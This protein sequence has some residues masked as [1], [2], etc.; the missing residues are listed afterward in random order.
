MPGRRLALL[1]MTVI[2]LLL[3]AG[4]PASAAVGDSVSDP[5]VISGPLPITIATDTTTATSDATDPQVQCGPLRPNATTF[6]SY[7]PSVPTYLTF[8]GDDRGRAAVYAVDG[9]GNLQDLGGC[10][11]GGV[12]ETLSAGQQYVIM[13]FSCCDPGDP[14]G[15]GTL[16]LRAVPPPL[17]AD[18]N[19]SRTVL[20]RPAGDLARISGTFS[21]NTPADFGGNGSLYQRHGSRADVL[22]GWFFLNMTCDESGGGIWSV[23]VPIPGGALSSGTARLTIDWG[24]V[25]WNERTQDGGLIDMTV[26]L[27][28]MRG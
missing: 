27:A 25:S 4:S 24:A 9:G 13:V 7:T 5:I 6:Y 2:L 22:I 1:L 15:L 16:G 3:G 18:L 23:D 11:I 12:T 8:A 21:C 26:R 17:E 10:V 20:I 14:G 19:V 28:P